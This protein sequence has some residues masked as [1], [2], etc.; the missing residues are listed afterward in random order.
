MVENIVT[1]SLYLYVEN[2]KNRV[3]IFYNTNKKN[4]ADPRP[5]HVDSAPET[6]CQY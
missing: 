3:V 6:T 4:V 5:K 2:T 1:L